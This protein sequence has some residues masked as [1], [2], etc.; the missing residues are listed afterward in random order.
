MKAQSMTTPEVK[1]INRHSIYQF[2]YHEKTTSK[3]KVAQSLHMSLTTVTQNL[4]ELEESG[5]ICR[6]GLY[7]ST[8]G[9]KAQVIQIQPAA[10]IAIGVS[11]FCGHIQFIAADLYGQILK[12]TII[13]LPYSTS[14]AYCQQLGSHINRFAE[15][16]AV[17]EEAVLGVGIAIQGIVSA[18]GSHVAYGEIL[19][20]TGLQIADFARFIKYPCHLTHDSKAAAF[21]AFWNTT[22]IQDTFVILL[23]QNLGS[24]LILNG[25]V[26]TGLH[27]HSGTLE[28][29]QLQ[30]DGPLCYCGHQGCLETYCSALRLQETAGCKIPQFFD[31]LRQHDPSMEAIWHTYLSHLAHALHNARVVLDCRIVLTGY[32]A[33][34]FTKEDIALLFHL[35]KERSF[36]S[37]EDNYISIGRYGEYSTAIGA[38]LYYIHDFI[39]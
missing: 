7:Q 22:P 3:Q 2:I 21:A 8:G 35:V 16:L 14:L 39:Q 13:Q 4:K 18:D 23:N 1:K 31:L 33:P 28:H 38:A 32:L 9:R 6:S 36:L 17:A 5:L 24:A 29:M 37:L 34:Y 10:R 19:H 25:K 30:E 12:Q 15:S 20:N 26:H 11:I 27:L